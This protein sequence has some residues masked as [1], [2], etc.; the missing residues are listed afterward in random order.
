MFKNVGKKIKDLASIVRLIGAGISVIVGMIILVNG[1]FFIGILVAGLG[2]F[3]SWLSVLTF[4]GFGQLI[5]NSDRIVALLEQQQR[6][7]KQVTKPTATSQ[8][9]PASTP[10]PQ[11]TATPQAKP[12]ATPQVKPTA[13][14][15][16]QPSVTPQNDNK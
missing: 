13:T 8:A 12:T 14:P 4:Y 3:L 1:Y 5:D 7:Q 16:A 6:T 10:Q 11:P 15:Q 2:I 9:K